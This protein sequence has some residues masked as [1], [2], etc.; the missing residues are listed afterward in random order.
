VGR[1]VVGR[2]YD[3]E[4]L[5]VDDPTLAAAAA[6]LALLVDAWRATAELRQAHDQLVDA[7]AEERRRIR[8]DLHDG[9]GPTLAGVCLG[10]EG[11]SQVALSDADATV[12]L[13]PELEQHARRAVEDVR[14][15]VDG[16]RPAELDVVGL[17]EAL[18]RGLASLDRPDTG[19][20][21][22]DVRLPAEGD[23]TGLPEQTETAVLR[24]CLEAVTNAV[25]HSGADRCTVTLDLVEGDLLL[26]VSDDGCGI[27]AAPRHGGLISMHDRATA[28]GGT[29]EVGDPPG[30]GTRVRAVLPGGA[31]RV[32]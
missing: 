7:R 20:P 1:L 30:G 9:L 13:L 18:R 2:R 27:G 6:Q 19:G 12:A 26:E 14:R 23:L 5:R 32:R 31:G 3:D 4:R 24:I 22:L 29:L 10:L 16:L 17:V 25:R 28:A 15:L 8:H 21:R 11:A